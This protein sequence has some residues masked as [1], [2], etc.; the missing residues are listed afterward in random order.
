MLSK[1]T[2][3]GRRS[4]GTLAIAVGI[5]IA[6]EAGSF[7]QAQ[8]N[9]QNGQWCAYFTGGPVN[10]SFTS[11]QQCMDAIR[12][13]TALCTQNAQYVQPTNTRPSPPNR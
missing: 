11:L 3:R 7:A 6:G 13:K 9:Q 4:I 5:L 10:C 12:G 1:M 2:Q 8:N